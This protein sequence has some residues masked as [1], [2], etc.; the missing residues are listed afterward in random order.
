MD[1][2]G[3]SIMEFFRELSS[4]T[5]WASNNWAVAMIFLIGMI[6]WARHERSSRKHRF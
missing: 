6:Y 5:D 2:I 4:L 1:I 3:K